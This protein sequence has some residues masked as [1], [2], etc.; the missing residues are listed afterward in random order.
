MVSF[1]VMQSQA[2]AYLCVSWLRASPS[3]VAPSSALPSLTSTEGRLVSAAKGV[4]ARAVVEGR[5]SVVIKGMAAFPH[6][7]AFQVNNQLTPDCH[8][9]MRDA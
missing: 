8:V 3:S 9:P 2:C 7:P 6:D 4:G 1:L 5:V